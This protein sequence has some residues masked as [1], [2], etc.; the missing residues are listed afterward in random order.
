MECKLKN[1]HVLISNYLM[2]D[3][4]EDDAKNFEE[5]Y[6][7][8]ETCFKEL[9]I[10]EDAINIIAKEGPTIFEPEVHQPLAES[11]D[12]SYKNKHS[13][14]IIRKLIFPDLRTPFR[15]GIA[16]TF[17]AVL[18]IIFFFLFQNKQTTK[19][20]KVISKDEVIIPENQNSLTADTLIKQVDSQNKNDFAE[21]TGTS[22]KPVTYLDEWVTENVRSENNIIDTV[23]SPGIEE[24]FYDSKITFQWKMNKVLE[25]IT[26]K[27]MNN[28]EK[29]IFNSTLDNDQ[30]PKFTIQANPEIFKQPGLYYWRLEDEE[31]VLY[32]GKFYF[33]K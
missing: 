19:N 15:R 2:G 29:E 12:K 16:F 32:V 5:H 3:L 17:T 21:L 20:E 18:A 8:C 27:I 14:N 6:F 13:Q 22:F 7:N 10:A 33:L 30:Y 24:K 9:K 23:F 4:P 1:R 26:I 31:E 11:E 25:G 28:L